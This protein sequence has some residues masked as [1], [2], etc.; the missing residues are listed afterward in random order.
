MRPDN[1]ELS[2][3]LWGQLIFEI[4]YSLFWIDPSGKSRELRVHYADDVLYDPLIYLLDEERGILYLHWEFDYVIQV[5]DALSG[6]INSIDLYRGPNRAGDIGFSFYDSKFIDLETRG[7]IFKYEY[8]LVRFSEHGEL[9]WRENF[10]QNT[11]YLNYWIDNDVLWYSSNEDT[12][13]WGYSIEQG[14]LIRA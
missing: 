8:G 1:R 6:E 3:G 13:V 5:V 11:K 14:W 2:L 12:S 4:P 7:V 9:L 10:E